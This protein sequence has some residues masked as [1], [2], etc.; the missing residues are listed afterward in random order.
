M[1]VGKRMALTAAM[2]SAIGAASIADS[3]SVATSQDAIFVSNG[4]GYVTIYAL[5]RHGDVEPI[6]TIDGAATQLDRPTAIAVGSS[7]RIYVLN[8]GEGARRGGGVV[9]FAA[10]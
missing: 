1:N 3:N 7:G 8:E 5:G 4:G 2:L 9:V 10:G 6:G